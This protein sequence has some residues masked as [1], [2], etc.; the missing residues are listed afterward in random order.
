MKMIFESRKVRLACFALA[1]GVATVSPCAAEETKEA[2][3]ETAKTEEQKEPEEK[4]LTPEQYFE[5]GKKTYNNW[6]EIGVGGFITSGSRA[7]AEQSQRRSR[8]AFGG[9]EDLHYQGEVA[10]NL[11]LTVD[12]R[13]LFDQND[14]KLTLGL[15]GP[16]KWYLRFNY[17][18]FRTWYNGNGG[19]FAPGGLWYGDPFHDE[20]LALDRGEIS[21]EGGLTLK[22]WPALTFKYTH[23][24]REGDKGSTSWGFTHPSPGYTRGL[25]PTFW[26]IDEKRDIFELNAKHHI[27]AT[28]FGL[29][30]RYETGDL[31]NARKIWQWPGEGAAAGERR[32]TDRQGTSYNL[33]DVHAFSETWIKKN[34]FFSA[35]FMFVNLDS[36]FSGSRIYGSDFDLGYAPNAINGAGYTNLFGGGHKHEYVLNLNLMSKPTRNL[37]ITPSIRVQREDWNADSSTYQTFSGG[38]GPFNGFLANDS[39]GDAIDVRERLDV[40]YTGFTN[41]VLYAQGEWTEGQGRLN[42]SGG[43][44]LGGPILRDSED[45]RWFQK[46]SAGVRWYPARK[47]TVDVGGYY[48]LNRYDYNHDLDSTLNGGLNRYPAYLV[49]QGFETFDGNVRLTLRPAP[50]LTLVSRYEYQLSTVHTKPASLSGLD[51]VESSEMTSHIIAQNVS[52][53]P[54]SRLYLQAGFNYVLSETR[55]SASDYAQAVLDSGNNYWTVN[56]NSGLALDHKTDLNLGYTYYRA[57]NYDDNSLAGLPYGAGAEEHGLT[58]TLVRRLTER[59]RLTLRY[60]YFH[61]KDETSGGHNDFNAHVLYSSLQYRF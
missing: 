34:L 55:T 24:Y 52:W 15:V 26:D 50:N 27:K 7:Q 23:Q 13:A 32:I 38:T 57:D 3:K 45:N 19:F 20:A 33:F 10:T 14:Y 53:S 12:G 39:D 51:E 5:G 11:N 61:S 22:K 18:E 28:D 42:E 44:Y 40:R 6:V 54:W 49:M 4:K 59:L 16:E 30:V 31:N 37:T 48:K 2:P 46:Y 43:S 58:A 56:F 36:D 41:W 60:G 25:S 17:E 47:V 9:I 8:G 35:G 21:F 1:M 29:G